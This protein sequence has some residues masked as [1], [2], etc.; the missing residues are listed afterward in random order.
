MKTSLTLSVAVLN[1]LKRSR[2]IYNYDTLNNLLQ[3]MNDF[4]IENGL[5]PDEKV[6]YHL[7]QAIQEIKADF[8]TRDDS[9]R[10]WIGKISHVDLSS[11]QADL[12]VIKK[13]ITDDLR[14]ELEENITTLQEQKA[15]EVKILVDERNTSI[16][17]HISTEEKLSSSYDEVIEE[18][19][20]L[21]Q[22]Y[23]SALL[24]LTKNVKS[25][26]GSENVFLEVKRSVYED[27]VSKLV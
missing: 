15:E 7:T 18:K 25:P 26:S 12:S 4:F 24:E 22:K 11:I 10:K 20:L 19:N 16:P 5:R 13:Y 21:L 1:K 27:I 8:K 9:L 2:D 14:K 17:V 3:A 6:N 23:H